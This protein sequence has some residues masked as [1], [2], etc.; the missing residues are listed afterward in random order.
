MNN[1]NSGKEGINKDREEARIGK[2]YWKGYIR[3][4]YR[5]QILW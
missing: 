5:N 2:G 4:L 1:M 3:L